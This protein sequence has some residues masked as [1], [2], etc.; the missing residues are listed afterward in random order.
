MSP[1]EGFDT[2]KAKYTKKLKE[3]ERTGDEATAAKVGSISLCLCLLSLC[4]HVCEFVFSH[5]LVY[6]GDYLVTKASLVHNKMLIE[7][8][9]CTALSHQGTTTSL[10]YVQTSRMSSTVGL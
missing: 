5:A 4:M 10:L 2:I 1:F 7:I 6:V 8:I 3:A 9:Y